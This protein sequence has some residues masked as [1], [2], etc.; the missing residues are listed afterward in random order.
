MLVA[1]YKADNKLPKLI[2]YKDVPV[3]DI[4]KCYVRLQVVIQEKRDGA[5][6]NAARDKVVGEK[7]NIQLGQLFDELDQGKDQG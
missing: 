2:E 4:E 6:R 1:L 5:E 7:K 3:Q